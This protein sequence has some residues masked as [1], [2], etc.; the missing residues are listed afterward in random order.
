[1]QRKLARK[2]R[3]GEFMR[4]WQEDMELCE[5]A[6]PGPWKA[7]NVENQIYDADKKEVCFVTIHGASM[8]G[9]R[10]IPFI[11]ESRE[12]LPYWLTAYLEIEAQ[13]AAMREALSKTHKALT[14]RGT[15]REGINAAKEA[16]SSTA[17]QA[18]LD[19][20]QKAEAVVEVA[21]DTC[22][23]LWG[24]GFYAIA[25]LQ[26]ALDDLEGGGA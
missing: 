20:L 4:N 21:K 8:Q 12:A 3:G 1:M 18:L 14:S 9:R 23:E 16:L 26:K 13:A 22:E 10:N 15:Y 17:G 6:T 24:H 25:T 2:K 11:A 7:G 5:N 19:R